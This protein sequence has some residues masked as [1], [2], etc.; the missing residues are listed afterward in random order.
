MRRVSGFQRIF[1]DTGSG[2]RIT[3]ADSND[4][5]RRRWGNIGATL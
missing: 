3:G 1:I 2:G 4:R 5:Q